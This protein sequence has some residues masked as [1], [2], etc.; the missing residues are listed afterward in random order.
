MEGSVRQSERWQW[1]NNKLLKNLIL[2]WTTHVYDS[3][4]SLFIV[5]HPIVLFD[6]QIDGLKINQN[7]L[8]W[9]FIQ[10]TYQSDWL[11][12]LDIKN[13]RIKTSIPNFTIYLFKTAMFK[14]SQVSISHVVSVGN[15]LY[16]RRERE[17]K[18]HYMHFCTT[19][20]P[21]TQAEILS[22]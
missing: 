20:W 19:K 10:P 1:K 14:S 8:K 3:V 22:Q 11:N 2:G 6:S 4:L 13:A 16:R 12:H 7:D 9:D 5:L 21:Q 15:I 18:H 17:K